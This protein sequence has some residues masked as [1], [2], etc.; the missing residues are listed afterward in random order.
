VIAV[1][2]EHEAAEGTVTLRRLGSKKQ[3]TLALDDALTTL[4]AEAVP[5]GTV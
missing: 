2:G 1:V 5:P 4:R 3:E